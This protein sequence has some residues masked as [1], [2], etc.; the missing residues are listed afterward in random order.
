VGPGT[1][2]AG[3]SQGAA[4]WADAEL[5]TIELA[6]VGTATAG[7]YIHEALAA[8]RDSGRTA[9]IVSRHSERAVA[10]FL[11]RH[12]LD[13]QIRHLTAVGGYP[14]GHLQTGP[15]LIEDTIRALGTTPADCALVTASITGIDT[16]RKTGTHAIGYATTPGASQNLTD[17]GATCIVQSL[18]D[19]TLR[20]RARPLPN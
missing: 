13:D 19:L 7:G 20:L 1:A 9:A 2:Q 10:D 11:D 4:A 18:A 5:A 3:V 15:H 8:C 16:A 17:V 6:A 12:G 14:P